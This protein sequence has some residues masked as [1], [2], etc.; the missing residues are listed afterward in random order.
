MPLHQGVA[1]LCTLLPA[2]ARVCWRGRNVYQTVDR[3]IRA[4]DALT[5][6]FVKNAVSF[7]LPPR[8]RAG[9]LQ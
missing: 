4:A 2:G 1:H 7:A 6:W 8:R 3:D 9:T 5:G